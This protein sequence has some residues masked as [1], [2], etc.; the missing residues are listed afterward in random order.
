MKRSSCNLGAQGDMG[1]KPC[2]TS[3][4]AFFTPLTTLYRAVVVGARAYTRERRVA[5]KKRGGIQPYSM[6]MMAKLIREE[7]RKEKD[8]PSVKFYKFSV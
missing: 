2:Q 5:G 7:V 3:L 1:I 4:S 8:L 6:L